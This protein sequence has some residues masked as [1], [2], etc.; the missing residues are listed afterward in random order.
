M[1]YHY[2]EILYS[3]EKGKKI[4]ATLN[5]IAEMMLSF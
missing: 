5:S 4:T 3:N 2:N 1:I